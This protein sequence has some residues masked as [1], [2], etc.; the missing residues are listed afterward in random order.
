MAR[1]SDLVNVHV[2]LAKFIKKRLKYSSEVN[3]C[4]HS[5]TTTPPTIFFVLH[6]DG[7][8]NDR[9]AHLCE[10]RSIGLGARHRG[11]EMGSSS[12]GNHYPV[13]FE[14]LVAGWM[15]GVSIALRGDRHRRTSQTRQSIGAHPRIHRTDV[16]LA[17]GGVFASPYQQPRFRFW[18]RKC[19]RVHAD[20]RAAV[21]SP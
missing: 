12:H 17:P 6:E 4:A 1:F 3:A 15:V 11:K 5:A 14:R 20:A 19:V 16:A 10:V 9:L 13:V 2:N 7:G 8:G 21:S 18:P